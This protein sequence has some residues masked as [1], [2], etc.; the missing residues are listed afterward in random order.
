MSLP[1]ARRNASA[2]SVVQT[3]SEGTQGHVRRLK[4][5]PAHLGQWMKGRI[6]LLHGVA[7]AR[8]VLTDT[9]WL[10]SAVEHRPVDRVG[11]PMPWITYPAIRLLDE[12]VPSKSRVF[13]YGGGHSTLWW[14]ERAYEVV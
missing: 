5:L 6:P 13:E 1:A 10:R 2:P 11:R 3:T 7:V 4:L 9:G 8:H 14:A 12:R